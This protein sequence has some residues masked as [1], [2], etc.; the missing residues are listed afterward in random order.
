MA[1]NANDA[2]NP[3]KLY[4]NIIIAGSY[5]MGLWTPNDQKLRVVQQ[6]FG[7][8]LLLKTCE[9]TTGAGCQ[10]INFRS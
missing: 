2:C 10:H 9:K 5:Q 3:L 4:K 1:I 7:L 8:G 6:I